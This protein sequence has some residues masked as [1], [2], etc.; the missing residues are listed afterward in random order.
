MKPSGQPLTFYGIRP[1]PWPSNT[2]NPKNGFLLPFSPE[3][4]VPWNLLKGHLPSKNQKNSSLGQCHA[5]I[6]TWR[7]RRSS[8]RWCLPCLARLALKWWRGLNSLSSKLG[9][10]SLHCMAWAEMLCLHSGGHLQKRKHHQAEYVKEKLYFLSTYTKSNS[11]QP[12][13]AFLHGHCQV[14]FL[15]ACMAIARSSS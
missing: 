13:V 12:D 1:N 10:L 7:L 8:S 11:S 15:V 5:R 14:L 9:S 4:A 2:E 3:N 6:S